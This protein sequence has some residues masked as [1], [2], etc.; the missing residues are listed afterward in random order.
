MTTIA[1]PPNDPA[2]IARRLR[3]G[4]LSRAAPLVMLA[5]RTLLFA[6]CQAVIALILA[7][8]GAANPWQASAA[9]WP[10]TVV[11]SNIIT[12]GLLRGLT[13]REGLRVADLFNGQ[14][15]HFWR[16]L[17][18]GAGLLL[19][20]G[21]L[22]YLPGPLLSQALWGDQQAGSAFFILPLPAGAAIIFGALLPISIAFVELPTYFGYCMP[23]LQALRGQ[24][25][26][27]LLAAA[28]A[29]AAQH[30]AMPLI[31]DGRFLAWRLLMFLPFALFLGLL[32]TWRPRL[33]PYL[34][35]VHGLMDL[36]LTFF[37]VQR[38]L[39]G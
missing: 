33:L 16:D 31:F 32:L 12:F 24:R 21:P 3:S 37:V 23:R 25:W 14:R 13:R 26:P 6:A 38:S 35:V 8:G 1:L 28:L 9:W 11:A 39:G 27:G 7:L 36:S 15:G 17:L 2:V 30:M 20:G 34:L 4:Q 19:V 5:A 29:L 18:A 10:A 22:G